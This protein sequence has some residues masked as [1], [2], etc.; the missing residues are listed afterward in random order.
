MILFLTLSLLFG[1]QADLRG[2]IGYCSF[3]CMCHS[4]NPT[5]AE[6]EHAAG[7]LRGSEK[8]FNN[9]TK[10]IDYKID[11]SLP[12][13]K[14][15]LEAVEIEFEGYEKG[16]SA[17]IN[18]LVSKVN[19][20]TP[21]G[22]LPCLACQH[23]VCVTWFHDFSPVQGFNGT[24]GLNGTNGRMVRTHIISL[25]FQA[26]PSLELLIAF[27]RGACCCALWP[28]VQTCISSQQ[29]MPFFT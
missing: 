13:S 2:R 20:L 23:S 17:V 9:V 25:I 24:N 19:S 18:G 12:A 15:Q 3:I 22:R 29:Y 11:S 14:G 16:T 28:P 7:S 26:S 1:A 6:T 4:V 21:V 8:V 5:F 10:G 27:I